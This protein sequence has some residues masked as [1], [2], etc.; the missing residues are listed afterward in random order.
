MRIAFIWR[1]LFSLSQFNEHFFVFFSVFLQCIFYNIIWLAQP[2]SAENFLD[3]NWVDPHSWSVEPNEL[4]K[5]CPKATPCEPCGSSSNAEYFRL[6]QSLF[7]PNEFRVSNSTLLLSYK[8]TKR[9]LDTTKP[10]MTHNS[11]FYRFCSMTRKQS[12]CIE[13]FTY[14]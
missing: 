5:L 14:T 11:N 6:V 1:Q 2:G 9:H 13:Q 12:L 7:N 3:P 8:Q 10:N 4:S